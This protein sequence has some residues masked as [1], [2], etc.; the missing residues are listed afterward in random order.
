MIKQ[1]KIKKKAV[2]L[3][4][5]VLMPLIW[6]A[7]KEG[8]NISDRF[9]PHPLD[10]LRVFINIAPMLI[11][12][13]LISLSR[14]LLGYFS[15]CGVALILGALLFK[16]LMFREITLPSLHTLRAIPSTATVPFFLLWF[17]FSEVGKMLIIVMG[18]AFNMAVAVLQILLSMK[19]KYV[20]AFKGYDFPREKIL[21][22]WLIFFSLESILPTLRF[23]LT[24][25]IGLSVVAEY[26]G[27]QS[28]LGYLIQSARTTFS[29]NVVIVCA[30]LYGII[31]WGLDKLIMVAWKKAIPW[32]IQ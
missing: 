6:I 13:T 17:G 7:V 18:I 24:V 22:S 29:F 1:G 9:L 20:I 26:L 3:G 27:A 28:G 25:A 19:E 15:G 8:F 10:V 16:H 23:S 4:G 14:I 31:A 12:H 30:T 21:F 5:V 11:K 32:Q 2:Q